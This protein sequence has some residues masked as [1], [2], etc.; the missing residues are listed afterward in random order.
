MRYSKGLHQIE[1][2][3]TSVSDDPNHGETFADYMIVNEY[4]IKTAWFKMT[5][6]IEPIGTRA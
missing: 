6:D 2:F 5:D 3:D 1:G 4:T